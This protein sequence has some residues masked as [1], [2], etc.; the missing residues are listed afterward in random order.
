MAFLDRYNQGIRTV[1]QRLAS[2]TEAVVHMLHK[3]LK[4]LT[5]QDVTAAQDVLDYDD[6]IDDETADIEQASV[7]LISLQQP[8]QEDLRVLTASLRIVRDL[9]RIADYA[10]DIAEVTQTL[11]ASPYFKALIDVPRMGDLALTMI[12]RAHEGILAKDVA[13]AYEVM[14]RDDAVDQLYVE[15]HQELVTV[16]R[17]ESEYIEQASNLLLVARYL[18]RIADHAVNIAEMTVYMTNGVRQPFRH[19]ARPT[20]CEGTPPSRSQ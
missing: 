13:I 17:A 10:C 2:L 6:V 5:E 18:E 15:L 9:E 11:A 8:R 4:S 19:S 16:M 20:D 1:E 12:E 7:E 3:S 14:K